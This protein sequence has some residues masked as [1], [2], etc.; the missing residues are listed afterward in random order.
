MRRDKRK[1]PY[2]TERARQW[3]LLHDKG[4]TIQAIAD[5]YHYSPKTVSVAIKSIKEANKTKAEP[6][7]M[8]TSNDSD[9]YLYYETNVL[10]TE[11]YWWIKDDNSFIVLT[12]DYQGQ[13]QVS[14][15]LIDS[16]T[17]LEKLL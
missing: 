9:F 2:Y 10:D 17:A 13:K 6:Q 4:M 5:M 16:K 1:H 3:V 12:L 7:K 11:E 15:E 14:I 8:F